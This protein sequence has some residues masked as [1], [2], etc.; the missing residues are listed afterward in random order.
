MPQ[1]K[2]C[3]PRQAVVILLFVCFCISTSLS[4]AQQND[5]LPKNPVFTRCNQFYGGIS[6]IFEDSEPDRIVTFGPNIG[7][8]YPFTRS[9]GLTADAGLLFGSGNNTKYTKFQVYAGPSLLSL[10]INNTNISFSP[11]LLAGYSSTKSKYEYGNSSSSYSQ[12]N[13]SM[14]AGTNI[15]F[16]I[17]R[18]MVRG[19][20]DFNPVFSDYGTAS[21][22]RIGIGIPLVA[23]GGGSGLHTVSTTSSGCKASKDSKEFKT[24]LTMI[25]DVTK[26]TEAKLNTIPRVEVK[27]NIKAEATVKQGEECC[28]KDLPPAPYTE[29]KGGVEGNIE[30]NFTLWGIPDIHYSLKLWPLL[31]ITDFQCKIVAGGTGKISLEPVGKFYGSLFGERRPDCHACMYWNLRTEV[32]ARIGAK[33]GGGIYLFHYK[34]FGGG[35]A[36]FDIPTG[37]EK[38]TDKADEAIEV[39]AEAFASLGTGFNGT[40]TSNPDCTRPQQGIHGTFFYGKAKIDV[41]ISVKLGPLSFDPKYEFNLF[42]GLTTSF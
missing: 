37:N 36:G 23:C 21:N 6:T 20:L 40:Y 7:F 9:L 41:R 1:P 35:V 38:L 5:T 39:Y 30:I 18:T 12:G 11:H 28:S 24:S 22:I 2:L 3:A 25:E 16:P 4:K 33:L 26:S 13:F 32:A 10:P 29:I 17:G 19:A 8:T 31:F 34:P 27:L 15:N 14:L 42:D